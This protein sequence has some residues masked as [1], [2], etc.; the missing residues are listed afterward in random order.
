M[1]ILAIIAAGRL[2]LCERDYKY[3]MTVHHYKYGM[4]IS[5]AV[6]KHDQR[7]GGHDGEHSVWNVYMW[8]THVQRRRTSSS[9]G[10]HAH[11]SCG[12]A[13]RCGW[14]VDRYGNQNRNYV[15]C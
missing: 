5:T 3:D 12:R 6:S 11:A 7:S 1:L 8:D 2:L 13:H 4:T 14:H 15:A 10:E 9:F